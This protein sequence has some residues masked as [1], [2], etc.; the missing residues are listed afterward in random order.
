MGRKKDTGWLARKG[1]EAW[2]FYKQKTHYYFSKRPW[3]PSSASCRYAPRE[4]LDDCTGAWLLALPW[5]SLTT[6]GVTGLSPA[7]AVG[8]KVQ[9]EGHLPVALSLFL[10]FKKKEQES[11]SSEGESA[12]QSG[13]VRRPRVLDFLPAQPGQASTWHP[14]PCP[15]SNCLGPDASGRWEGRMEGR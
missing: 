5:E 13:W 10:I 2:I 6:S 1:K 12:H 11:S 15:S 14:L 9:N 4:A 3:G 8:V 7:L